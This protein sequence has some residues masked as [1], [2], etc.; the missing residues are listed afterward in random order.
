MERALEKIRIRAAFE[1]HDDVA[2]G[3][4]AQLPALC[5]M[6]TNFTEMG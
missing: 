3:D 2:D 1:A 5:G 6:L 4:L